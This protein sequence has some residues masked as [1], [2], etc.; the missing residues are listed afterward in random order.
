MELVN[1]KKHSGK[2]GVHM[3][4]KTNGL[5]YDD[6]FRKECISLAEQGHDV[7]GTVVENSNLPRQ[8]FDYG[9]VNSAG[10]INLTSIRLVS[11]QLPLFSKIALLHLFEFNLRAA[12][13]SHRASA[14]VVWFH[15][16]ILVTLL[17]LLLLLRAFSSVDKLIWDQH[18]LPIKR[19]DN[20]ALFRRVFGFFCNRVDVLIAANTER[21]QYLNRHY[22]V[23]EC[24]QHAVIRNFSDKVFATQK[25]KT[26][27][28]ELLCWLKGRDY[29]LVQ[30]GAVSLRNFETIVAGVMQS[31]D[32]A[33]I[34]VVGGGDQKLLS[35]LKQQYADKFEQKVYLIGKVPQMEL[36]R[37]LDQALGSIILYQKKFGINNWLC[38]PNRLFQAICRKVPVLVGSNPTMASIVTSHQIGEVLQDDGLNVEQFLQSALTLQE[39][40]NNFR[41][42]LQQL[43]QQYSW[44]SQ[45]EMISDFTHH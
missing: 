19:I 28:D 29:W 14:K 4:I 17:P 26:L 3:I 1:S 32:M 36:T 5:E 33:P 12:W 9:Q 23:L 38:E 44:D 37:Y 45:D 22:G 27:P 35:M 31:E 15:D 24:D 42:N 21:L 25:P 43:P 40:V 16:P 18:E 30:S 11:K 8:N 34:V 6:R 41:A 2:P 7:T 39:N 10:R 13:R 20:S